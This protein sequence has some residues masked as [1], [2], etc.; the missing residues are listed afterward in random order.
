MITDAPSNGASGFGSDCK[1]SNQ[2]M[3]SDGQP[4]RREIKAFLGCTMIVLI[5]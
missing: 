5:L 1:C 3:I 4:F 2:W